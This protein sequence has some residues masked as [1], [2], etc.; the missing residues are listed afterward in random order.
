MFF[1]DPNFKT[2]GQ[3]MFPNDE[4]RSLITD[5]IFLA[6]SPFLILLLSFIISLAK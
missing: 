4:F 6:A 5:S 2:L 3:M 1:K